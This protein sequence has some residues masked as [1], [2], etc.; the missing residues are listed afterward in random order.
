MKKVKKDKGKMRVAMKAVGKEMIH[1]EEQ[2]VTD[3]NKLKGKNMTVDCN[4]KHGNNKAD[5]GTGNL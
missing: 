4:G 1:E 2:L 5:H 3:K